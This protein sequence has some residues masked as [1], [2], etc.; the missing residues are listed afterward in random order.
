MKTILRIETV[1]G[2]GPYCG[3]GDS[4]CTRSHD[5]ECTFAPAPERDG[6]KN[7]TRGFMFG[8]KTFKQFKKWFACPTEL[9][10]LHNMG[11]QL[12][13]YKVKQEELQA[14][15]S[16]IAFNH[17]VAKKVIAIPLDRVAKKLTTTK[18]IAKSEIEEEIPF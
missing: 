3:V 4:W 12:A 5:W 14:G 7:F 8:F 15:K 1:E 9:L 6:L 18:K 11:Y 13:V 17:K 16:Q 2:K 10:N